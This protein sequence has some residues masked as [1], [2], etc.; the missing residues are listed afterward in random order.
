MVLDRIAEAARRLSALGGSAPHELLR[1]EC[2]E[3]I[4][5]ATQA[6]DRERLRPV[7]IGRLLRTQS[8]RAAAMLKGQALARSSRSEHPPQA[9]YSMNDEPAARNFLQ[10]KRMAHAPANQQARRGLSGCPGA[11]AG[12]VR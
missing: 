10:D 9:S 2:P 3:L 8:I 4:G 1:V 6:A 12:P 11:I 7:S 5:A